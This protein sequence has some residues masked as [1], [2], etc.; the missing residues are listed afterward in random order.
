LRN[1]S[2][3][4]FAA[5][6]KDK[7]KRGGVKVTE[8]IKVQIMDE[9]AMQRA[10]T[11]IAFEIV[12]RNKGADDILILGIRRRGAVIAGRIAA[13]L[14]EIEGREIEVSSIDVSAYR[15]DKQDSGTKGQKAEGLDVDSRS[16]L[17]VDDV[18][19]TGR[20]VRAAINAI[21]DCGR[22]KRILL[23]VMADRGHREL[24]IRPDFVGKNIP[25]SRSEKVAVMVTEYDGV[26]QVCIVENKQ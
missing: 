15:D 10:I 21:M 25:T 6:F 12:E 18:L 13:K 24:P 5:F 14:Q 19:Y 23:A 2:E 4:F 8:N 3:S 17:L 26:N 9:K 11:R 16:I 22:P 7:H 20:T 1:C